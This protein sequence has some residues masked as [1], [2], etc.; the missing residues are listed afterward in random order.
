MSS[1]DNDR[2][3]IR[4]A[5]SAN[6]IDL[7]HFLERRVTNREDAAD[8]LGESMLTAWRKVRQL[9]AE[10]EAARMWLFVIARYP[11]LNDRRRHQRGKELAT[12]LRSEIELAR[13]TP[14]ADSDPMI[15]E[16]RDTINA[17]PENMAELVRL[18]HWDGF[19]LPAAAELLG[20]SPST[21]R[22]RHAQALQELKATL[23]VA[24][25]AEPARRVTA[26]R[27]R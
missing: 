15:Y 10:P 25:S 8:I 6:S 21:A 3:R 23:R 4:T 7:L 27:L 19:S 11:L 5:F 26:P 14:S 13:P 24:D 18:V 9:P 1:S 12:K 22:R 17:L 16:V 2:E 20:I